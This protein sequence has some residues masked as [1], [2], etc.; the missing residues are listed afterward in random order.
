MIKQVLHKL[1]A[2]KILGQN[3]YNITSNTIHNN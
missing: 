2:Q 1:A 3:F